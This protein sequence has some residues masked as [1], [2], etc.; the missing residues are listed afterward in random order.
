MSET[1]EIIDSKI[2]EKELQNGG[3][4][5][6]DTSLDAESV[7]STIFKTQKCVAEITMGGTVTE[8]GEHYE[9]Q[10]LYVFRILDT[11]DVKYQQLL[12]RAKDAEVE[13]TDYIMVA[14]KYNEGGYAADAFLPDI[15]EIAE[16]WSTGIPRIGRKGNIRWFEYGHDNGRSED[17]NP[18]EQNISISG[19]QLS[20]AKTNIE[21]DEIGFMGFSSK[22]RTLVKANIVNSSNPE[23]IETN[24]ETQKDLGRLARLGLRIP[25]LRKRN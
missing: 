8:E 25:R 20:L 1:P 21:G 18:F 3:A 13:P 22:S 7:D 15:K 17:L 6:I 10:K 4:I 19:K 11:N 14:T 5:L 12:D 9:P 23:T 24:Q 16:N 2:T